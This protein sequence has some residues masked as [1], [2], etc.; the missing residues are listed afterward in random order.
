MKRIQLPTFPTNLP[1][2][3][4]VRDFEVDGRFVRVIMELDT[5]V[6]A[7]HFHMKAQ[8][9]EM[10]AEGHFAAAPLGYPSRTVQTTH[11]VHQSAL[12]DT[13]ELDDAWVR[14]T[15]TFSP[16]DAPEVPHVTEQPTTPGT[17]Y[18]QLVW[19]SVRSHAW[20]W[21]EGFADGTARSK[22]QDLGKVLNTSAVRS[23]VGF[24]RSSGA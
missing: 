17:E 22:V 19:D 24:R 23:G 3:V 21:A 20:R 6:K 14:H 2:H 15:G 1:S 13:Q 4:E 18:G 12:G 9:Y 11:T 8:A 16:M 7:D 10:T 5:E